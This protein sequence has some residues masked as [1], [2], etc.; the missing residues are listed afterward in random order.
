MDVDEDQL[1]TDAPIIQTAVKNIKARQKWKQQRKQF[2]AAA[3]AA[4]DSTPAV[5]PL[6]DPP[7][8]DRGRRADRPNRARSMPRSLFLNTRR[9]TTEARRQLST[10]IKLMKY[11][12]FDG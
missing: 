3:T 5:A 4:T 6:A 7:A 12:R 9:N 2:K 11:Y 1:F 8:E 10:P